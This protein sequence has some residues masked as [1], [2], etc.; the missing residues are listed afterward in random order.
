MTDEQHRELADVLHKIKGKVA[1]SGYNCALMKELYGDWKVIEA[2]T[3]ACH[4][5]KGL[6]TE[7]LWVNYELNDENKFIMDNNSLKVD[8]ECQPQQL[9]LI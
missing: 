2:P 9:S 5:T 7:L 4:S 1:I 3:K 8:S 6:R